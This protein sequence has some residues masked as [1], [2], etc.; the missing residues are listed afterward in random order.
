MKIIAPVFALCV[1]AAPTF[2]AAQS[3][4][5]PG[6]IAMAPSCLNH[7]DHVPIAVDFSLQ[8]FNVPTAYQMRSCDVLDIDFGDGTSISTN[9]PPTHTYTTA[10]TYVYS[11]TLHDV[12]NTWSEHVHTFLGLNPIVIAYGFVGA[13]NPTLTVNEGAG[14][15]HV[16]VQ[17][18][19]NTAPVTVQYETVDGSA[20]AGT[21]Y[22]A[23]SGSLSFP[24]AYSQQ[25]IDVPLIDDKNF[26][27][28]T[29]SFS[30]RFFNP[31]GG[32]LP[33]ASAQISITDN[34]PP[35][36]DWSQKI[37]TVTEGQNVTLGIT[38]TGAHSVPVGDGYYA[39]YV[40]GGVVF[41]PGETFKAVTFTVPKDNVYTGDRD[42]E[43]DL[44]TP[45]GGAVLPG[46]H[47]TAILHII[48]DEAPPTLSIND[49][50]V[51]EGNSGT[52]TVSFTVTLSSP[53]DHNT[54]FTVL[55]QKGAGHDVS[56]GPYTILANSTTAFVPVTII[57]DTEPEAD[58]TFTVSL[59]TSNGGPAIQRGTGTCTILN[60][61]YGM[62]PATLT[63]PRGT[64]GAL[65][66]LLAT[67]PGSGSVSATSSDSNVASVPANVSFGSADKTIAI[68]VT[69]LNAGTTQITA[70]VA[71]QTFTSDVTVYEPAALSF[72][73][74]FIIVA[75]GA[76]TNV[77]VHVTPAPQS[78]M[79]LPVAAVDTAIVD[80]PT[81]VAVDADG[82]G[83][84]AI[85]GLSS[86]STLVG[87]TL[88]QSSGGGTSYF[89]V[90][91]VSSAALPHIDQVFSNVSVTTGGSKF[92]MFG[93]NFDATC[94]VMFGDIAA[95]QATFTSDSAATVVAPPHAP[96][97]VRLK[98]SCAGIESPEPVTFTY[99]EP[100]S[101]RWRGAHH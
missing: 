22:V 48:D 12:N 75:P 68:P 89:R 83:T 54:T 5:D 50:S 17:N 21:N 33:G 35:V 70:K 23:T 63:L 78:P 34:D 15:A 6:L 62:A 19:A 8:Y 99:L 59:Q 71:G 26:G 95:T 87:V 39:G 42:V 43:I 16:V 4:P 30:V 32:V 86:G 13:T 41:N 40:S 25:T 56:P 53:L 18:S 37:Y 10:G 97:N 85:K 61:D 2:L 47:A 38:C 1:L 24:S 27:G 52:K 51:V 72:D 9:T 49:I 93:R 80:A 73:S 20:K 36:I 57:G 67:N 31:T 81:N 101:S 94:R 92:E 58:E 28:T 66:I 14:V 91:V 46:L 7:C 76:T 84:I 44:L 3:C 98:V 60:D 11:A 79:T 65:T 96:G 82:T 90:Q 45:D 55:A 100:Q 74:D 64:S 29:T 69:A 77:I 88:P